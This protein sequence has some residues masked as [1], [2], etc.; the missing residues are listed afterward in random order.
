MGKEVTDY[1]G[2]WAFWVGERK[3]TMGGVV[4][5]QVET[6]IQGLGKSGDKIPKN[7]NQFV[8][9]LEN[10]RN[11]GGNIG[12]NIGVKPTPQIPINPSALIRA[13]SALWGA[14]AHS[15]GEWVPESQLATVRG[16]FPAHLFE[17]ALRLTCQEMVNSSGVR[18]VRLWVDCH[19][20]SLDA[21][22]REIDTV[23]DGATDR[24]PIPPAKCLAALDRILP[25]DESRPLGSFLDEASAEL[26]ESESA[27]VLRFVE[28]DGWDVWRAGPK[29]PRFGAGDLWNFQ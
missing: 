12:V 21:V 28:S 29:P 15:E 9:Y 4:M 16:K 5:V 26:S 17:D 20:V 23:L 19:Q 25:P 13:C 11:S 14:L 18:G 8:F 10:P 3:K 24:K 2:Y 6:R 27:Q 7:N 22:V 1:W